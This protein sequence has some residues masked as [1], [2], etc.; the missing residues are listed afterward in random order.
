MSGGYDQDRAA[1][2]LADAMALGDKSAARKWEIS[3]RTLRR[4]RAR[5]ADEP[6]LAS[7]VRLRKADVEQDLATMRV[8]FL[9]DALTEM[10]SKLKDAT[11][12]EVSGAVKIV[13]ELHQVAMA[14]DDNERPDSPDP[15]ASEDE[16][17]SA[18]AAST[19]H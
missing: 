8:S 18:G 15:Q 17:G 12:Y 3:E 16:G 14:V 4:Y 11:L 13:G 10:K 5:V 9:R 6:A 2:I 7:L 19:A 1:L